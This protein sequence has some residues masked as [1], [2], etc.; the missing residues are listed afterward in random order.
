MGIQ[1][2]QSSTPLAIR[3]KLKK[4]FAVLIAGSE[5][6]TQQF[7]ADT[8]SDFRKMS[9]EQIAFPRGTTQVSKF[10][11]RKTIYKKGTPIHVRAALLYNKML[12]DN[13]LQNKYEFIQSGDKIKF[14]YLKKPNV[15]RENV[16]AFKDYLPPEFNLNNS[17]DYDT[18]FEKVF[19]KPL[20]PILEAVNWTIE[21]S[22]NLED[23]FG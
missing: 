1:A 13:N 9:A 6:K 19:I 22:V 10:S 3:E 5:D 20:E 16:I 15:L 11:D 23:I 8:K 17:I 4:S 2:I 18:Q 14:L 12:R 7:I 21:P